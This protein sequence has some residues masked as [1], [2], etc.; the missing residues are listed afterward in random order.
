MQG[1]F[2]KENHISFKE[3][4]DSLISNKHLREFLKKIDNMIVNNG[5]NQTEGFILGPTE[6]SL[7]PAAEIGLSLAQDYV[8]YGESES[9]DV[10]NSLKTKIFSCLRDR[11]P[12]EVILANLPNLSP[13][14]DVNF[15][16]NLKKK[17]TDVKAHSLGFP[18]G[19]TLCCFLNS[20]DVL[21]PDKSRNLKLTP[22]FLLALLDKIDN[23]LDPSP[24]ETFKDDMSLYSDAP[25]PTESPFSELAQSK[26]GRLKEQRSRVIKNMNFLVNEKKIPT[27]SLGQYAAKENAAHCIITNFP[28][29][30]ITK[31]KKYISSKETLE[32]DVPVSGSSPVFLN[33][34]ICPPFVPKSKK[35]TKKNAFSDPLHG[36]VN[37]HR[38]LVRTSPEEVHRHYI[39]YHTDRSAPHSKAGHSYVFPCP[40]CKKLVAE[41]KTDYMFFMYSCC[42]SCLKIHRFLLHGESDI[43]LSLYKDVREF[44][45]Q[46]QHSL[47]LKL[48]DNIFLC[49]CHVC[50]FLF[51]SKVSMERHISICAARALSACAFYGHRV[52]PDFFSCSYTKK[53]SLEYEQTHA[54]TNR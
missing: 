7:S 26:L 11:V 10:P 48:A 47:D 25:L 6:A 31:M 5:R 18:D 12:H 20:K 45:I 46:N 49:K 32:L 42:L 15:L 50:G 38:I 40:T 29:K 54:C 27:L 28:E 43:L 8:K 52:V 3:Y 24:L 16:G 23:L 39:A 9:S 51:N 44:V 34:M 36:D 4:S 1:L 41:G 17:K 37:V 35:S 14:S 22:L 13:S 19:E 21:Q 53:L 30:E 33:C 2:T